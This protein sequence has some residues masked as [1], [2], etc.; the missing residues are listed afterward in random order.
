[1]PESVN[2]VQILYIAFRLAPFIIVSY[3]ALNSLMNFT[4]RGIIYL[5]GLLIVSFMTVIISG[6][7]PTG[8]T[9]QADEDST[10]NIITLTGNITQPL[11]NLPLSITVYS[12]TLFNILTY[13]LLH[14]N[15]QAGE[16]MNATNIPTIV[17]FCLLI[18]IE[19][20]S[21]AI[22][23]KCYSPIT[24]IV[25]FILGGLGGACW[26]YFIYTSGTPDMT[27]YSTASDICTRP[28]KL[29]YQCTKSN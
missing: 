27:F 16:S 2:T 21:S 3:F 28:S 5:I 23:N 10:C 8:L 29:K 12:Y 1:M 19:F 4:I 9:S 25:S 15:V 18:V 24:G 13:V 14:V 17:F 6:L 26:A 20:L 11:S 7:I 22:M